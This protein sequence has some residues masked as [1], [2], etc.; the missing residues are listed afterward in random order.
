MPSFRK[1]DPAEVQTPAPRPRSERAEIEQQYDALLEEF[2]VGEPHRGTGVD[3][4]VARERLSAVACALSRG[5]GLEGVR[6]AMSVRAGHGR[7]PHSVGFSVER[8]CH[9]AALGGGSR[10]AGLMIT[11]PSPAGD[12]WSAVATTGCSGASRRAICAA[13]CSMQACSSGGDALATH[14]SD[15]APAKASGGSPLERTTTMP[16]AG[17]IWEPIAERPSACCA[18][19]HRS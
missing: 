10:H 14:Q 6:T 16:R 11:Q 3:H 9:P 13:N 18:A 19:A 12:R 2:A 4:L 5:H 8:S 17:S 7:T 15:G 1:V